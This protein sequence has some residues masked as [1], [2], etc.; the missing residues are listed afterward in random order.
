MSLAIREAALQF[1]VELLRIRSHGH[2]PSRQVQLGGPF[3]YKFDRIGRVGTTVFASRIRGRVL[4]G[5]RG[6]HS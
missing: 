3:A 4:V 2:G 5:L 6:P 1:N